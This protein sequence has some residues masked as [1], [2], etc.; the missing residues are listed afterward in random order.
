MI[1]RKFISVAAVAAVIPIELADAKRR[2]QTSN[3]N[4]YFRTKKSECLR[5][6]CKDWN[7]DDDNCAYKCISDQ[8]YEQIYSSNPLELGEIDKAREDRFVTCVN[9]E[10]ESKRRAKQREKTGSEL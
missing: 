2:K 6:T 8:C 3:H 1:G 10:G 4:K 9:G 7:K 5:T